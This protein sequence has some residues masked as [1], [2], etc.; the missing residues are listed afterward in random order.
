[1]VLERLHRLT[2]DEGR[3]TAPQ[4]LKVVYGLIQ[5]MRTVMDGEQTD[6]ACQPL[7]LRKFPF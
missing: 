6:L 2:S 7:A 1:M 3:V 4:I 5:N